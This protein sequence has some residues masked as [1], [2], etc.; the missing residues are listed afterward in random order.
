MTAELGRTRE[1]VVQLRHNVQELHQGQKKA[2]ADRDEAESRV[3]QVSI[4]AVCG[5]KT[6][7]FYTHAN[8]F[9]HMC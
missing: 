9:V 1:E 4:F 2:E 6:T 7:P 5:M 3:I 8:T